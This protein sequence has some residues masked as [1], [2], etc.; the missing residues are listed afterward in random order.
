MQ[1][2]HKPDFL[3]TYNVESQAQEDGEDVKLFLSSGQLFRWRSVSFC[4]GEPSTSYNKVLNI[5]LGV[6][7]S[8]LR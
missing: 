2:C 5:V 1:G 8:Y 4:K 3:D 7:L 6:T